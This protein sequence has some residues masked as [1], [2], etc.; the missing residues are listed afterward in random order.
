MSFPFGET[1]T[2]HRPGTRTDPYSGETVDD[3][4]T[5]TTFEVKLCA[6]FP[7][8]SLETPSVDKSSVTS[9]FTILAPAGTVINTN[10]RVSFRNGPEREVTGDSFDWHHPFTGWEPGVAFEVDSEE[11]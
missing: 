5:K 10:D 3:W 9:G 6:I 7:T 11:R 2:V 4:T 1:I 8:A